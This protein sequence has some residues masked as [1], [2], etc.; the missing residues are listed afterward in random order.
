MPL[1]EPGSLGA[2]VN[3]QDG[4]IP[5]PCLPLRRLDDE[6]LDAI[7]ARTLEPEIL[8]W[9]DSQPTHERVVLV[10]ELARDRP[11]VRSDA[12]DEDLGRLI[13]GIACPGERAAI[14][15][16]REPGIIVIT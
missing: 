4:R 8:D 12:R 3:Q 1:I 9:I 5:S 2:A 14:S 16:K 7:S 10:G 15:G 6:P 11:P 13:G